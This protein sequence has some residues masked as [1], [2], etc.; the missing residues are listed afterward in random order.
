[1]S[2]E[3]WFRGSNE[4]AAFTWDQPARDL[5]VPVETARALYLRAMQRVADVQRAEMLYLRWLHEAAAARRSELPAPMPGRQTRVLHETV[6][7]G[8]SWKRSAL[9]RLGPGKTTRSLLEA[10][11]TSGD[12]LP[13]ADEAPRAIDLRVADAANLVASLGSFDEI[14]RPRMGAS[15]AHGKAKMTGAAHA[16]HGDGGVVG[17]AS[18]VHAH[19]RAGVA[20]AGERLPHATVIQ[21]CFGHHDISGIRAHVGG[22]ATTASAAIGARAYATGDDIAFAASPDLRQAAHEAAHVVQQRG[23]V[24]LDGGVGRSGDPFEQHADAVADLVVRGESAA[25][26]LDAMGHHGPAGGPAVQRLPD[27]HDIVGNTMSATGDLRTG[28]LDARSQRRTYERLAQLSG[29]DPVAA[30]IAF[31]AMPPER[32]AAALREAVT[33]FQ[34]SPQG[35]ALIAQ[36]RDDNDVTRRDGSQFYDPPGAGRRSPHTAPRAGYTEGEAQ[37][38]DVTMQAIAN[39]WPQTILGREM[40]EAQAYEVLRRLVLGRGLPFEASGI[41]VVGMR[42]FQG[43]EMHDN[44]EG[45][46]HAPFMRTNHYDDTI[47]T[48]TPDR[49]VHQARGTVDPGT[50]T[51]HTFQVAADQQ[52]DYQGESRGDTAKFDRPLYGMPDP[53][54]VRR[55]TYWQDHPEELVAAVDATPRGSPGGRMIRRSD[56]RTETDLETP[57][58]GGAARPRLVSAVHSGGDGGGP[59][60]GRSDGETTLGDS[61]GCSVVEGAWFPHF[62]ETLRRAGGERVRFTYSLIDPRTYTSRQLS[63]ILDSVVPA[64]PAEAPAT[65]GVP[66][67]SDGAHPTTGVPTERPRLPPYEVIPAETHETPVHPDGDIDRSLDR[68]TVHEAARAGVAGTGGALPHAEV[69]QASFGHHDVSGVRAHVGGEARN[70]AAAIGARAYATGDDVAFADAPDVRQAAHEA[71]HIVQQRGGVRLDGGVGHA[72][73]PYEQNAEAVAGAVLRGESAEALLDP[74]AHRG[75]AGGPAVQRDPE[76][77]DTLQDALDALT[78]VEALEA[79]SADL[80]ATHYDWHHDAAT[81]YRIHI[82]TTEHEVRGRDLGALRAG[83]ASRRAALQDPHASDPASAVPGARSARDIERFV[84]DVIRAI[85]QNEVHGD[86]HAP[87]SSMHTAA[88]PSASYGNATQ[89]TASHTTTVLR[90]G[91][92]TGPEAVAPEARAARRDFAAEHGISQ[93]DLTHA[94]HIEH[95]SDAIWHAIVIDGAGVDTITAAQREES[96]LGDA[97]LA[98]MARLAAFR[99]RLNAIRERDTETTRAAVAARLEADATRTTARIAALRA[100]PAAAEPAAE[101]GDDVA[102]RALHAGTHAAAVQRIAAL[103]GVTLPHNWATQNPASRTTF[104]DRRA[105]AVETARGAIADASEAAAN[106]LVVDELATDPTTVALHFGRSDISAYMRAGSGEDQQAWERVA[107]SR[108]HEEHPVGGHEPRTLDAALQDAATDDGGWAQVGAEFAPRLRAYLREH[109]EAHDDDVVRMA[110]GWN[111]NAPGY[112]DRILGHFHDLHAADAELAASTS[113]IP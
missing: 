7:L 110:A 65:P 50:D 74:F 61:V 35:A 3:Q 112:A 96:G 6:P 64:P 68:A 38:N 95:V 11:E 2:R 92:T 42:A 13:G 10:H 19:A 12:A 22:A 54:A 27:S 81:V 85:A 90:G 40:T 52:W 15:L 67:T 100:D 20:G 59:R 62:N 72:G 49:H 60:G 8:R 71:A 113:T 75:G 44:G 45:T 111:G 108:F 66:A 87:P 77:I 109:P 80:A 93:D 48:L 107:L 39:A 34:A 9:E 32:R 21:A 82:G 99:Q 58:G 106:A 26:L 57:P 16:V 33:Q 28:A 101:H 29:R 102:E 23:G 69:I 5:E 97:D 98:Q 43:G 84:R 94:D 88:G 51:D 78:T 24:R 83:V 63:Q 70:A 36:I 41:N 76:P 46:D 17:D 91:A 103:R 31:E 104:L 47:Y 53:T 14:A 86:V 79:T 105:H 1:M 37:L 56:G 55:G 4:A 89:A 18:T 73:D 25:S 30:G